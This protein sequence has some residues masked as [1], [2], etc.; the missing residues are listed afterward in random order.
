[1]LTSLLAATIVAGQDVAFSEPEYRKPVALRER[2]IPVD[3]LCRQLSKELGVKLQAAS[4]VR[5]LKLA[6]RLRGRSA[7]WTLERVADVLDLEWKRVSEGYE[8]R[9]PAASTQ[10]L[11][12]ARRQADSRMRAA[13]RKALDALATAAGKSFAE[14]KSERDTLAAE[15]EQMLADRKPGW[16]DRVAALA[17]RIQALETAAEEPAYALGAMLRAN[18]TASNRLLE[19]GEILVASTARVPGVLSFAEPMRRE[20]SQSGTAGWLVAGH[21]G[22]EIAY[23]F[24]RMEGAAANARSGQLRIAP[25]AEPTPSRFAGWS[26]TA[27]EFAAA[28]PAGPIGE[29]RPDRWPAHPIVADIL[30]DTAERCDLDLVAD[31][32]RIPP[33]ANLP[34]GAT[35]ADLWRG[36]AGGAQGPSVRL[37]D[38]AVLYRH[39]RF[40]SLRDSEIPERTLAALDRV[41]ATDRR[42]L[43]DAAAEFARGLTVSQIRRFAIRYEGHGANVEAARYAL[44]ALNFWGTLSAGQRADALERNPILLSQMSPAS[45]AAYL[46]AVGA[47]LLLGGT[48]TSMEGLKLL[49]A[50]AGAPGETPA[51]LTEVSIVPYS[52]VQATSRAYPIPLDR[53]PEG[54]GQDGVLRRHYFYFGFDAA[55][56]LTYSM[57]MAEPK[58]G[59]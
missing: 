28:L 46:R 7:R 1:M 10:A 19:E 8:L 56:A 25:E 11:R 12:E 51:F 38:G 45:R 27:A 43:F 36:L 39:A 2:L 5:D 50:A 31:A 21:I 40:W 30:L 18:P 29:S 24:I 55:R 13:R 33:S 48:G 4:D 52:L 22:G 58:S 54:T 3:D 37:V 53:L 15:R 47:N 26:Q 44:P 20:L 35:A 9:A 59:G 41:P 34:S 49:F 14:L 17:G 6:L 23:L 42:A 16:S 32:F 57:T